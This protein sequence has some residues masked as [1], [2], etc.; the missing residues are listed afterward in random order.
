MNNR[1][2]VYAFP[3]DYVRVYQPRAYTSLAMTE[4]LD[5]EWIGL[6]EVKIKTPLER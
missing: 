1:S 5:T 4:N 3:P 2:I 6:K